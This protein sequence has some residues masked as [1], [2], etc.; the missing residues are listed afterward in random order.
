MLNTLSKI[1][2]NLSMAV[3]LFCTFAITWYIKK[4]DYIIPLSIIGIGALISVL[5]IIMFIYGKKNMSS[6]PIRVSDI[7]PNDGW[8][9]GYVI[10][11]LL[12]FGNLA[13]E[14]FNIIVCAVIAIILLCLLPF[15]NDNPPN[16]LLF[17]VGY[18]FYQISAENGISGYLLL[19]KRKLRRKQDIK[20]VG[21]MFD[22]LLLDRG[23]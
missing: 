1:I 22:Y 20:V 5:F 8:L 21:Q 3:P 23:K 9:V 11:Y 4:D 17:I 2:Y 10:S 16:L 7:S 12:P 19:S 14:D 6:M 13:F 15:F 18:H